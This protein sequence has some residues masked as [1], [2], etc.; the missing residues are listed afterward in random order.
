ML[1]LD[2]M[3]LSSA[4]VDFASIFTYTEHVYMVLETDVLGGAFIVFLEKKLF[5]DFHQGV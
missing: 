2:F 4:F 1:E 5:V 3:L